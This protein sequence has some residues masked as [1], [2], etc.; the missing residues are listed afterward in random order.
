MK[1]YWKSDIGFAIL[2]F[3]TGLLT[4]NLARQEHGFLVILL[5]ICGSTYL[6]LFPAMLWIIYRK[7]K[8]MEKLKCSRQI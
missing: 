4:I 1:I 5:L 7:Y 3:I 8:I 2:L 6:L